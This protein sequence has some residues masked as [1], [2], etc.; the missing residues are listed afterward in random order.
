MSRRQNGQGSKSK[1]QSANKSGKSQIQTQNQS[2]S[3]SNSIGKESKTV[4]ATKLAMNLEF[5]TNYVNRNRK[6]IQDSQE[7]NESTQKNDSSS[8][9][10]VVDIEKDKE[11]N[12]EKDKEDGQ[13]LNR[14]FL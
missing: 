11:K 4:K 14:L 6:F 3:R 2:L 12:N 9:V 1:S 10:N 13:T 5:I 7:V 8:V